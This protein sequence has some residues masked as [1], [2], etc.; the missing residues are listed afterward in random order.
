[1]KSE[2]EFPNLRIV[3]FFLGT[4][5]TDERYTIVIEAKKNFRLTYNT[6]PYDFFRFAKQ[7]H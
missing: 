4:N 2:F 3:V 1:M 5:F 6:I 7:V